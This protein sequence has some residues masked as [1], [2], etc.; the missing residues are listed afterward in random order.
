MSSIWSFLLQTCTVSLTACLLL[1]LKH[2]LADKLSPRWQ[3]AVWILLAARILIPVNMAKAVLLPLPVWLETLKGA[4]EQHLAS[5]Y[6]ST[7]IPASLR[8]IFPVITAAPQ[9]ITDWLFLIYAAGILVSLLYYLI[10]Y[11][12]LRR[13][14]SLG[15]YAPLETDN[16][17]QTLR[18]TYHLPSCRVVCV[19]GLSNAFI[20]G[21]FR[22]ILALPS[23]QKVDDKILLHELLHLKYLDPLQSIFWCILRALHWCNPFLHYIFN[24]I[25]NDM[26]SLCDQRVLERLEGEERREYGM[27]L[28]LMANDRYARTP[29]TSSISNGGKNISRR[30]EAIVRFKKYPQGMALVSIC[31][32]L[33][34]ISPLLFGTASAFGYSHYKPSR[35]ADLDAAMAMARINRC[36]TIA[37]AIDA[38]AKG[39]IHKN[40]I[41]LAMA[42]PLS[43]HEEL[44]D[45]MKYYSREHG[46]AAYHIDGGNGMKY[47]DTSRDYDIYDLTECDDGSYQAWLTFCASA[48]PNEDGTGHLCD[49]N[50]NMIRNGGVL[51]PI[52]IRYEDGWIVEENGERILSPLPFSDLGASD[53][54]SKLPIRTRY[55][56]EGNTGNISIIFHSIYR[57][58]AGAERTVSGFWKQ[59]FPDQTPV[60]DANF[61]S[62]STH[63]YITY[64]LNPDCENKPEQSI[65]L[66]TASDDAADTLF[67]FKEFSKEIMVEYDPYLEKHVT[68]QNTSWGGNNQGHSWA[69]F[70]LND[71]TDQRFEMGDGNIFHPEKDEIVSVPESYLIRIYWDEE[72]VDELKLKGNTANGI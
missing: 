30:I 22:P 24:R 11:C 47:A 34:L 59:S 17:I 4:A 58:G 61:E 16:Q 68:S 42:S 54:Y 9:S 53:F 20:C 32:I 67:D 23:G 26:E 50:G 5:V 63:A 3:Y 8:H 44:H 21:V 62:V 64:T 65:T 29:G 49:E 2:I 56:A 14:L 51:I 43:K 72:L 37:G 52:I 40:G 71:D 33:T 70:V 7:Y 25:G 66:L 36:T 31:I 19:D 38:Y 35:Y 18:E 48:F 69:H 46:W 60:P 39:L 1:V 15:T 27:L 57:V 12:R 41:Y 55:D 6:T 10:S 45:E 28:L 13:L